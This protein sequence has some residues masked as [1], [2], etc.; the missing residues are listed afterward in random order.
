[1]SDHKDSDYINEIYSYED[2]D[3]LK[4]NRMMSHVQ[5]QKLDDLD[6]LAKQRGI[7]F[8][9]ALGRYRTKYDRHYQ[10]RYEELVKKNGD[11]TNNERHSLMLEQHDEIYDLVLEQIRQEVDSD[12]R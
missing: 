6:E 11:L 12:S 8:F 7:I 1:M 10:I 4:K 2:Y 9:D 5:S 3:T